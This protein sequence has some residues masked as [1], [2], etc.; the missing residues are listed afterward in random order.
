MGAK[1]KVHSTKRK[2]VRDFLNDN[3]LAKIVVILD[4]RSSEDGDIVTH[5]TGDYLSTDQLGPVCPG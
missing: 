2:N 4:T 3:P 1:K 5:S